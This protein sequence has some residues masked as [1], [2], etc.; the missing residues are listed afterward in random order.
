MDV[1]IGILL[2]TVFAGLRHAGGRS[3]ADLLIVTLLLGAV[4]IFT[5]G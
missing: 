5:R 3:R 2:L 1:L 4:I